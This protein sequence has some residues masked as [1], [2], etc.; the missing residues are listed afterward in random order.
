MDSST[1]EFRD[2]D[3]DDEACIVIRKLGQKTA[4]CLSL[5]SNGD[6]EVVMDAETAARL[7]Q[8]LQRLQ[9]TKE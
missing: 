1:I 7:I 2:V 8:E 6:T 3:Q 9:A 4:L 5:R